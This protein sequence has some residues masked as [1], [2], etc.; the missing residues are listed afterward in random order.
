[1][2]ADGVGPAPRTPARRPESRYR[3]RVRRSSFGIWLL[4]AA[5]GG[6]LVASRLGRALGPTGIVL[7]I[8][9]VVLAVALLR[10]LLAARTQ[11]SGP[12]PRRVAPKNVTPPEPALP[13]GSTPTATAPGATAPSI[14]VVEPPDVTEQLASKLEALD[15]L[16]ADGLVTDDEY[17]AKRAQLIEDF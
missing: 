3:D 8:V 10:S 17:E 16:R 11:P 5:V 7:T 6:A 12:D 4:V 14:I 1:M 15:R 2:I 13:P 9:L